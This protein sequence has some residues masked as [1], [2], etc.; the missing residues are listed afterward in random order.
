MTIDEILK[1]LADEYDTSIR[2]DKSLIA[3][4]NKARKGS[5]TY[6]DSDKFAVKIGEKVTNAFNKAITSADLPDGVITAEV[7]QAVIPKLTD[8]S[9]KSVGAYAR[10]V[11]EATNKRGNVG[12]KALS[13][14]HNQSR[15]DGIVEYASD[16]VYEDIKDK[17]GQTFVN[18]SQS[19]STGTLQENV[20]A[21]DALGLEPI[22]ERIY[23]GVGL[24]DGKTPCEWCI[25]REGTWRYGD[26]IANGVFQRHDGCGCTITYEVGN[27]KQ[28]QTEWKHNVWEDIS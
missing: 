23:D 15:V 12:L 25:A 7:A 17:L 19:I 8:V 24:H 18:Y 6:A 3:L 20:K 22:V 28:I 13:H 10:M 2:E 14:V 11:Q 4:A 27:T 16:R 21:Q 1:V 26:A 9:E 5:A